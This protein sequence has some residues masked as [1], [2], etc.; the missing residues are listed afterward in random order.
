MP[1]SVKLFTIVHI[2][3]SSSMNGWFLLFEMQREVGRVQNSKFTHLVQTLERI[4]KEHFGAIQEIRMKLSVVQVSNECAH[5]LFCSQ[6]WISKKNCKS[7]VVNKFVLRKISVNS[8][9]KLRFTFLSCWNVKLYNFSFEEHSIKM[10][11][12]KY[13]EAKQLFDDL[14][15]EIEHINEEITEKITGDYDNFIDSNRTL[16]NYRAELFEDLV[17]L[18]T[19]SRP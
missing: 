3:H 19:F 7:L 15:L 18:I 10:S 5:N 8:D 1:K 11:Q 4:N 14:S 16:S 13:E 9:W 6:L 2:S 12:S 17:D